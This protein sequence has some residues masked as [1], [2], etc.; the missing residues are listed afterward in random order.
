M[1]NQLTNSIFFVSQHKYVPL[2][3][4]RTNLVHTSWAMMGLIHSGQAERDPRP[5]HRAAKLLINSQMKNGDFPQE[6][7]INSLRHN[8]FYHLS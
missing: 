6:V 3:E 4:N 2:E 7:F 8:Q 5:L 1:Y